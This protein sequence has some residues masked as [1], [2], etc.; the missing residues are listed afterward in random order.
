MV[1][2]WLKWN[3]SQV[4]NFTCR[5]T[6]LSSPASFLQAMGDWVALNFKHF[7]QDSE[8]G[9][10]DFNLNPTS[11]SQVPTQRYGR[12]PFGVGLLVA[13]F[14]VSIFNSLASGGFDYGLE[15]V[16]FNDKYLK[17]FLWNCYQVNA[18]I[19][20]WSLVNIGSGNGLVPSGNK[21]LPEP[22]LTQ[23]YVTKWHP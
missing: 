13:G 8:Q 9:N 10:M 11:E 23:I 5:K 7:K 19:P 14:D 18:T 16:I 6:N 20:L 17:Y 4:Y 21:P 15:L 2:Q 1:I 3:F 12:R 22:M